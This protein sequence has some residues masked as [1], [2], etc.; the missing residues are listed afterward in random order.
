MVCHTSGRICLAQTLLT[1]EASTLNCP[2]F[3]KCKLFKGKKL[4]LQSTTQYIDEARFRVCLQ[5]APAAVIA[6]FWP[7]G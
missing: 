1:A 2:P 3:C 5:L 7:V 6:L 4:H